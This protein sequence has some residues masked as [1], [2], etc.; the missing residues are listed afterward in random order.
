VSNVPTK[1]ADYQP[2]AESKLVSVGWAFVPRARDWEGS[3]SP[4]GEIDRC[5]LSLKLMIIGK[6]LYWIVD[7]D[8]AI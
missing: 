2:F 4:M 7:C 3:P 8:R 1:D 6:S 5:Y